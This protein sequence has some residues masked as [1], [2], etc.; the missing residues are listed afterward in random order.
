MDVSLSPQRRQV[1]RGVMSPSP[2]GRMFDYWNSI[3]S[4]SRINSS[5]PPCQGVIELR[6]DI[7]LTPCFFT[8]VIET[9]VKTPFPPPQ[10]DLAP[11]LIPF[12]SQTHKEW[13]NRKYKAT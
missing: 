11:M 2:E 3:F 10:K 1:Q 4:G 7:F 13:E 6:E 8:P 12:Y 5:I 9:F